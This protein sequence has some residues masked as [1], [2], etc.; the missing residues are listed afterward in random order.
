MTQLD[1]QENT[2]S[3]VTLISNLSRARLRFRTPAP[4]STSES[5]RE[6]VPTKAFVWGLVGFFLRLGNLCF[7]PMFGRFFFIHVLFFYIAHLHAHTHTSLHQSVWGNMQI[8]GKSSCRFIK[9]YFDPQKRQTTFCDCFC[10]T[11]WMKKH[12][13]LLDQ[14]EKWSVVISFQWKK[15]GV[16]L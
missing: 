3:L 2:W 6:K 13:V 10:C 9:W 14:L 5:Y 16:V 1:S 8:S 4:P 15:V 11:S 7:F 12:P